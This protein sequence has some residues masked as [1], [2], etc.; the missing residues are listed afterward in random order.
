M[1]AFTPSTAIDV[2]AFGVLALQ[3]CYACSG[4]QQ[5]QPKKA[6]AAAAALSVDVSSLPHLLKPLSLEDENAMSSPQHAPVLG[7]PALDAGC[8]AQVQQLLQAVPAACPAP[9]VQ[10]M[11]TCVNHEPDLR[12]STKHV[13]DMLQELRM[14][15]RL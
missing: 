6:S 8:T 5:Q 2:Y 3:L 13:I 10:L 7:A 11:Q 15:L 4:L 14:T 9:L 1:D 12:P